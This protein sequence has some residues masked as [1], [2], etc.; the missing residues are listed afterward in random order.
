MSWIKSKGPTS[1]IVFII[2][3]VV[4]LAYFIDVPVLSSTSS[5]FQDW[6]I[7]LVGFTV[8]LG[9]VNSVLVH[10]KNVQRRKEDQWQYSILFL[11]VL[12]IHIVSGLIDIFNLNHPV[13]VWLSEKV[14]GPLS[15]ASYSTLGFWI[16][17]AGYRALRIK[18]REAAVLIITAVI[19]MLGNAPVGSLIWTGFPGLKNWLLD[20]PIS[21]A[22]R[23]TFIGAG[24]AGILLG[25]RVIFGYE[26]KFLGGA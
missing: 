20:V 21:A 23:S 14:Y 25:I 7:I 18:N 16:I 5:L 10:S 12:T 26:K 15:G 8:M 2:G 3:L 19:V 4:L 22:T 13:Y 1:I 11:V 9:L 17:S 24:V 6:A